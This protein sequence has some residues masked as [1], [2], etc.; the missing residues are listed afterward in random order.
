MTSS[1]IKKTVPIL[2]KIVKFENFYFPRQLLGKII[3][4]IA[5]IIAATTTT[6][7]RTKTTKNKNNIIEQ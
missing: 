6:T 3:G 2:P 1:F 7:T 4:E 5:A